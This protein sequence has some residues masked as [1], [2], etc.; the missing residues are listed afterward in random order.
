M[1]FKQLIRYKPR[2]FLLVVLFV[3]VQIFINLKRGMVLTPFFHYGMY[4]QQM[5][6][7]KSYEVLEVWVDRKKLRG[8]DFLPWQWD[9]IMQPLVYF[10][11]ISANNLL[12]YSN[13]KRISAAVFLPADSTDFIIN[14]QYP[15]FEQWYSRYLSTILKRPV[16]KLDLVVRHYNL[17]QG[18]L[19][20][21]IQVQHLAST[22]R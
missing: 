5:P 18:K 22:C 4:S 15:L 7:Q 2:Y 20:S 21:T 1:Y 10:K 6:P 11:N 16:T 3:L 14:C 12:Y 13:V 8:Q 17:Q 19:Q 9:K